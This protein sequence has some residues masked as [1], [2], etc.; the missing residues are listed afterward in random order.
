MAPRKMV[1][2]PKRG[3]KFTSQNPLNLTPEYNN[4]QDAPRPVSSET[5]TPNRVPLLTIE[6]YIRANPHPVRD[7]HSSRLSC[8]DAQTL[9]YKRQLNDCHDAVIALLQG[10]LCAFN[11]YS[12]YEDGQIHKGKILATLVIHVGP[13]AKY[14]WATI[15]RGIEQ[16]FEGLGA[17]FKDGWELMHVD[18]EVTS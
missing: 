10:N 12:R 18:F 13:G 6:E 17:L 9:A 16:K 5:V 11:M 15:K 14:D 8:T 3:E 1:G 4:G 7:L 2:M